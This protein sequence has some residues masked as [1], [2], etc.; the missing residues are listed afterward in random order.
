M[1]T[2]TILLIILFI[3]PLV[4][5]SN[6]SPGISFRADTTSTVAITKAKSMLM[7]LDVINATDQS[8]FNR[9]EK[10]IVRKEI[11]A[12]KSDLKELQGARYMRTAMIVL[13]LVVPLSVFYVT[14]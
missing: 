4:S 9:S 11:K 14:E 6:A 1:K 7:R 13:I 8:N 2:H 12:I 5:H 3:G 10:R